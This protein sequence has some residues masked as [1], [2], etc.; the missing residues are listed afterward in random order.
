MPEL[1]EGVIEGEIQKWHVAPG[2]S[3]KEDSIIAE[4][5]T[6]KAS[7]EVPSTASGRVLDLKF[8]EGDVCPVGKALLSLEG[9]KK[10]Q[11]KTKS[12]KSKINKVKNQPQV[13]ETSESTSQKPEEKTDEKTS[14]VLAA[15]LVRR[16][17]EKHSIDLS[18]VKGSGL[19]GR[20]TLQDIQNKIPK[21]TYP[22][23][24]GSIKGFSVPVIGPEERKPLRGIRKKIA[25]NMQASKH[26][27]PHFT[28]VEEACVEEL[29]H[30][31]NKSKK[32][33][34]DVKITYLSFII[35]ILCS[36]FKDFPEFNASIDDEKDQIVY[37][38]YFHFGIAVDTSRGLLVPVVRDV[39]Q[40]NIISISKE[41]KTLSDK[42]RSASVSVDEMKGASVTITNM[43]SI[44]GI[45]ATPIINPPEV[46]ILGMYRMFEKTVSQQEKFVSKK[47]MNFSLTLDHRLIDGGQA[48]RFMSQFIQRVEKPSLI[49]IES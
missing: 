2:D 30:L 29:V 6:D 26:V 19:S 28:L 34:P 48:A 42:A 12:Q 35:K 13:F 3:I 4:V 5:M 16:E 23:T 31:R 11:E 21:N 41:I 36:C 15:P 44:S 24:E 32:L 39:D 18:S 1:G 45:L 37:K 8:K 22:K 25:Q 33:Y 14:H 43:G 27:I 38:K 20:V 9:E 17:A 46:C 40:K 47:F 10:I 7:L 49:L